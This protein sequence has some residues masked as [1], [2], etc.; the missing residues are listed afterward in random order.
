MK[1]ALLALLCAATLEGGVLATDPLRTFFGS[2]D[3]L[4]FAGALAAVALAIPFRRFWCHN[5]CPAGAFLSLLNRWTLLCRL[6]P[7]THV[8]RCDLG[9]RAPS[10]LDC[11]RCDRCR[12]AT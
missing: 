11:L 2:D 3:A 8:G 10:D 5:L 12:H 1:Y 9:V 6:S 7:T 4:V